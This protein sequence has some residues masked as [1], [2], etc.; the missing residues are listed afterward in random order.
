MAPTRPDSST[1]SGPVA[2]EPDPEAAAA[3]AALAAA[4]LAVAVAARVMMDSRRP[5]CLRLKARR[6]AAAKSES[7][8]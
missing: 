5:G 3:A 8:G 4:E 2:A 7:W 6:A 1:P